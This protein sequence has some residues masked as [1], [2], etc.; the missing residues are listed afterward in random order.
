M[1]KQINQTA[2]CI[3]RLLVKHVTT[4]IIVAVILPTFYLIQSPGLYLLLDLNL[5][6]ITD[7]LG[8]WRSDNF[9]FQGLSFFIRVTIFLDWLFAVIATRCFLLTCRN[10]SLATIPVLE[11]TIFFLFLG[12]KKYLFLGNLFGIITLTLRC[13]LCYC[14]FL[15]FIL[16]WICFNF[17]ALSFLSRTRYLSGFLG[18]LVFFLFFKGIF[19]VSPR[20][21]TDHL[22]VKLD[23]PKVNTVLFPCVASWDFKGNLS[24]VVPSNV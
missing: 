1:M 10:M 22:S 14:C 3:G 23:P 5:A 6:N 21:C 20:E 7:G 18:F 12:R 13:C 16:F 19:L 11:G 24:T 17:S 2:H 15:P 8:C 9:L 4:Y